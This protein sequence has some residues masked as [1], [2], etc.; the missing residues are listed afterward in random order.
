VVVS[1]DAPEEKLRRRG[2]KS[3]PGTGFAKDIVPW[4]K[5]ISRSGR[6]GIVASPCQP[7]VVCEGSSLWSQ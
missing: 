1:D 3:G 4:R 6:L 2:A 7:T 5:P